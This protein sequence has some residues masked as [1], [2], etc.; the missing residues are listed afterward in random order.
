MKLLKHSFQFLRDGQAEMRSILDQGN[1]FIG[2]VEEDHRCAEH[3]DAAEHLYIQQ[4]AD[5]DKREDEQRR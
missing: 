5:A 3:T 4:M 1:A 2:Q